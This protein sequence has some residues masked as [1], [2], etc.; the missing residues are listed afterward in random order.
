LIRIVKLPPTAP[1]PADRLRTQSP[2][3]ER[4]AGENRPFTPEGRSRRAKVM[5]PRGVPERE[6]VTR[7]SRVPPGPIDAKLR[8]RPSVKTAG[9][10]TWRV[11]E[12]V[13]TAVPLSPVTTR[14]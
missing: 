2:E 5:G 12:S 11:R 8:L 10:V 7:T 9:G 14:G 4:L 6:S 1:L 13:R 3:R